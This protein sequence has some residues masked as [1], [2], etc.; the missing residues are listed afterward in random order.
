M[1]QLKISIFYFIVMSVILGLAYPFLMTGI[2]KFAFPEKSGG[3]LI[4]VD[5]RICGSILIGQ[6]FTNGKYFH[7]RPSAINYDASNSGGSNWGPSNKKFIDQAAKN[8]DT[9]R[10]ENK[11]AV[12]AVIPADLVLASGSGL[13][14]HISADSAMLQVKRVASERKIS[15]SVV[16]KII[17]DN[18]GK[19]YFN[20]FGDSYVNVLKL[21]IALDSMDKKI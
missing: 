14:P 13:D 3:S 1:K 6:I 16:R 18:T 15:E 7:G 17:Q 10:K 2:A 5:N 9:I 20:I 4:E 11:L 21:N 12:D 8:A 19:R